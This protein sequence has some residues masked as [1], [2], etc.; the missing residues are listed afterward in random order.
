MSRKLGNQN[1]FRLPTDKEIK[2]HR[3]IILKCLLYQTG[4]PDTPPP[5]YNKHSGISRE[6]K[7]LHPLQFFNFL[8]SIIKLH[9]N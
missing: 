9:V 6:S 3:T 7:S 5:C 4:L 2:R 8:F 1:T